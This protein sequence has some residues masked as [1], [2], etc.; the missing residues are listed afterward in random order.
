MFCPIV[1]FA[2][3]LISIPSISPMDLGCQKLISDR[4]IR[5]GF[6]IEY[7][8]I[9]QTNNMWAYRGSGTTLAFAG[10]TDVVPAGNKSSWKFSPF[11]PTVY[12]EK[13]FG[14]G[15][16]DMKGALAAMVVAVENFIVKRPDHNGRI[17][18]LITSD[19]ESKALD[20]TKRVVSNL[21]NRKEKIDYCIIGEPSSVEKVG[22]VIKNGRRGSITACICVSGI[23][24]H[25][26]YPHLSDNPIHKSISFLT[27]LISNLWDQGNK[28][29]PPTSI[30]IY[31][32]Q[33]KSDSSNMIPNELTVKFNVRFSNEITS[34]S[35]KEKVERLLNYCRIKYSIKWHLSGE[36][37]LT[38]SSLLANIVIKSIKKFHNIIPK[39]ST[40][41]GTSDGR[42]ISRMGS[43]IIELGLINKTIHK[44]N[45]YAKVKDL[46]LL[47]NI[48][49]HIIENVFEK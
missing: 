49:E 1:D 28:F 27:S 48:Y 4:L 24:G 37:F 19:E 10:H 41:G 31:E 17:A 42:F 15:A 40:S 30:Q 36:P 38:R 45:E 20:G 34:N 23:P 47:S 29:F 8:N 43:Q 16:S 26:A 14:R 35:I 3:Q 44:I 25:I 21:I 39:L 33:S 11:C 7:M 6:S 2:K 46:K 22:D 9:N 5:L 12:K 18:F 32:I 13:L